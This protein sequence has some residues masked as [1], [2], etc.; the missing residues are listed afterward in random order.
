MT[1][2]LTPV[3]IFQNLTPWLLP[4]S[5]APLIKIAL[6]QRLTTFQ[7]NLQII[8]LNIKHIADTELVFSAAVF[9]ISHVFQILALYNFR[10]T[11][12]LYPVTVGHA[13]G[14]AVVEALRYE[15]EGRGIDPRCSHWNYLLT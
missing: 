6:K 10:V 13:A 7:P 5:V 12:L 15:P 14:G 11:S 2:M 3:Y 1:A 8:L 4:P 9:R